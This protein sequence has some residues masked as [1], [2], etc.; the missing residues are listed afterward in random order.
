MLCDAVQQGKG[1]EAR[2]TA[3]EDASAG[4]KVIGEE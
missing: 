4:A 3:Y 2:A 1:E